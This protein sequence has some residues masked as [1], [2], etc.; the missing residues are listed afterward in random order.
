MSPDTALLAGI[1]AI[2]GAI[3]VAL[4]VTLCVQLP[5]VRRQ[6]ILAV[7]ALSIVLIR[8]PMA[9]VTRPLVVALLLLCILMVGTHRAKL[10]VQTGVVLGFAALTGLT[11]I[12]GA[13]AGVYSSFAG[14]ATEAALYVALVAFAISITANAPS[15][16]VRDQRIVALA[17]A[18]SVYCAVSLVLLAAGVEPQSEGIVVGEKSTLLA[19]V[20]VTAERQQF[21]FAAGVNS[22]G[23]IAA[24]GISAC[25]VL[26]MR[27]AAPRGWTV[28]G[29]VASLTAMGLSDTRLAFFVAVIIG[30]WYGWGKRVIGARAIAVAVP[31]LPLVFLWLVSATKASWFAEMFTRGGGEF[32]TGNG[33]LDIWEGVWQRLQTG[34]GDLLFGWGAFGQVTSG[35]SKNYMRMF[36][37]FDNPERFSAHNVV[38]QTI[39]DMGVVGLALLVAVVYVTASAI[40]TATRERRVEPAVA[41][42]AMILTGVLS[43]MTE[44]TPTYL[45]QETLAALLLASGAAAGLRWSGADL[46]DVVERHRTD[47]SGLDVRR[48]V[49]EGRR[50]PSVLVRAVHRV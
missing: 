4:L 50:E 40:T 36:R 34:G 28:A 3:W 14:T 1:A 5:T 45:T 44:A 11:V 42:L 26:L 8:L 12:R 32:A 43:G 46:R 25:I 9:S 35:A 29:L 13:T 47:G 30:A 7:A 49:R 33:R 20:G 31:L 48:D 38:L 15:L 19:L 23:V 22:M 37:G 16:W 39:L 21:P 27:R 2:T 10:T 17:L 18:P 24:V 6:V 41:L